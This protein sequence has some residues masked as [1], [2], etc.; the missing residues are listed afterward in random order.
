MLRSILILF[1]IIFSYNSSFTQDEPKRLRVLS[2]NIHYGIGMDAQ[3]D[4]ARIAR[5]I[6]RTEP[7][8]VGLQEVADSAMT[9]ELSELLGMIGVFGASTEKEIPNLYGLLGLPTP[10]A[11]LFYGDAILS[12]YPFEYVGNMSIPSASSSRYEVMGIKVNLSEKWGREVDLL[13]LT[14]HFDYLSTI[15]SQEARKATVEVIE[16]GFFEDQADQ[17]AI[18]TGD[19]NAIPESEPLQL[20]QEKGWQ[21]ENLNKEIFTVPVTAP[22]KQIDYILPR[23]ADK[24]KVIEVDVVPETLASDHLPILMILEWIE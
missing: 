19:L 3:K 15:G 21:Y 20:L 18:L 17:L 6:Q 24:W 12:K 1:L 13:F 14:T 5:V 9:A 8:I 22:S 2:Y 7:D 23:P 16:R 11:P 4:L 10:E